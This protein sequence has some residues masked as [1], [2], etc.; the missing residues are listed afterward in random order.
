MQ[1]RNPDFRIWDFGQGAEVD[2]DVRS[3]RLHRLSMHTVRTVQ[4]T[5]NP[6]LGI[7][8]ADVPFRLMK[9]QNGL[10]GAVHSLIPKFVLFCSA[11]NIVGR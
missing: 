11:S 10:A 4:I 1:S 6:G 5:E 8:N 9:L 3:I 7:A 2:I